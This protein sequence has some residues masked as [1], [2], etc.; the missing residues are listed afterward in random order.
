M[1]VHV[2]RF[3]LAVAFCAVVAVADPG[4]S[5][6]PVAVGATTE[7][8]PLAARPGPDGF[9][10]AVVPPLSGG[11]DSVLTERTR[12]GMADSGALTS[13]AAPALVALA[14]ALVLAIR[15]GGRRSAPLDRVRRR[16]PPS[17]LFV[18]A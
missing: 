16:G 15:A 10:V 17:L 18:R 1:S 6:V 7:A 5:P 11:V 8:G 2:R 9:A 12:L 13:A 4:T 14:A 3:L